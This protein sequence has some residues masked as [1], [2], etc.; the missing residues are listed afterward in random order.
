[1]KEWL[2][3]PLKWVGEHKEE[4]ESALLVVNLAGA[5]TMMKAAR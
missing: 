4:L 1:M 2:K 3:K 5:V